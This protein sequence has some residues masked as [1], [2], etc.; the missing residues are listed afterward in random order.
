MKR[1]VTIM[2]T[3]LV[4]A[5][6]ALATLGSMLVT[7]TASA[8]A[9]RTWVS[10]VGDDANPCSRT[11]P[12]KTFAGAISKTAAGG[13][14]NA[15]DPGAYGAV[16]ITKSITIDT[17]YTHA[18]VLN[19]GTSGIIVNAAATDVVVLRGLDIDS[20]PSSPGVNGVRFIAGGALHIEDSVIRDNKAAGAT[21]IGILF[22]PAAGTPELYVKNTVLTGNGSDAGTSSALEIVPTVSAGARVLIENSSINNN[23][24]GVRV[25]AGGTTGTI[26]MTFFNSTVS[27][28]SQNGWNVVGGGPINLM[29]D[30]S[31]ITN[32]GG[33]G[34]RVT[35]NTAIAR[36]GRSTISGNGTGLAV[37][38]GGQIQSYGDNFINGNATDGS[39]SSTISPN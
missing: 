20:A 14:I 7:E 12:C 26:T 25:D 1:S 21:G 28:N 22:A 32:N 35:G 39:P 11:A 36:I 5:A 23:V 30:S 15:I 3:W 17:T 4:L 10:G 24:R 13:E 27:G 19:S 18:G 6:F 2:K 29:I 9:V 31:A 38:S 16:T 33:T 37:L 8:Q 34:L